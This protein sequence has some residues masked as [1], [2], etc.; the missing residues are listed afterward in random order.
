MET[1]SI[2][3]S[4]PSRP[5]S[6]AA[7]AH[8]N[9][10]AD[11]VVS[12]VL[13]ERRA[14]SAELGALDATQASA[15]PPPNFDLASLVHKS[16]P[17]GSLV[18]N[19]VGSIHQSGSAEGCVL[20]CIAAIWV[21]LKSLEAAQPPPMDA[22]NAM[23]R[24]LAM[25]NVDTAFLYPGAKNIPLLKA[26]SS[27][28]Y[29]FQ[30]FLSRSEQAAGFSSEAFNKRCGCSGRLSCVV[31]TSGPG[32]LN[33]A[34]A[35]GSAYLDSVPL[36]CIT[37]QVPD[38]AMGTRAFQ[39]MPITEL[40]RPI[41][42]ATLT[43]KE[44]D[45]AYKH[46]FEAFRLLHSGRM[47]PVVIDFPEN[48]QPKP[49]SN[50][51]FAW[52]FDSSLCMQTEHRAVAK[53]KAATVLGLVASA[54]KPLLLVGGGA[55][56]ASSALLLELV[57]RLQ[58]PVVYTMQAKGVFP[59]DHPLCLGMVGVHGLRS[60]NQALSSCTVLFNLGS[61]FDERSLH[62][63]L[64]PAVELTT[65]IHCDIDAREIGL[66]LHTEHAVLCDAALLVSELLTLP[67]PAT[68]DQGGA[69]KAAWVAELQALRSEILL[70]HPT[71]DTQRGL[72]SKHI[73]RGLDRYLRDHGIVCT[74]CTDVGQN[75]VVA[76]QYLN[77]VASPHHWLNQGN[78]AVSSHLKAD[79][80]IDRQT[81]SHAQTNRQAQ[82]Q[83]NQRDRETDSYWNLTDRAKKEASLAWATRCQVASV[84]SRPVG[85]HRSSLPA[86]VPRSCPSASSARS[87]STASRSRCSCL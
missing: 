83:T 17:A 8:G 7:S 75:Q 51:A 47:G 29:Q 32:A 5:V 26:I 39:E 50:P 53:E 82:A 55:K 74:I 34:S 41:C 42:K 37:G 80:Q 52:E 69:I 62:V 85:R 86:T 9:M 56:C 35:V 48:I 58:L 16:H 70:L 25:C 10:E 43:V 45:D 49:V 33:I 81:V 1:F 28:P 11:F 44:P 65:V 21:K 77:T 36:L 23:I 18:W 73:M 14:L 24:A 54:T 67:L 3:W 64:L 46:V 13:D 87:P 61:R 66:H 6:P 76:C 4:S 79:R 38:S 59:D 57:E 20:L 60:A 63:S 19:R 78:G 68:A 22:A 40:Y 31:T 12:G 84:R 15:E 72:S 71:S 2:S 27:N 30:G